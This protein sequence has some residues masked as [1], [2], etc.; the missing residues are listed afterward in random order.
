MVGITPRRISPVMGAR[1]ALAIS[2]TSSASRSSAFARPAM[3]V[4]TRVIS[5]CRFERSA[6]AVPST[7]SRSRMPAL[8]VD[9]VMWQRSAARPKCRVSASATRYWSCFI[10]GRR[11]IGGLSGK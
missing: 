6:T 3:V 11:F 7:D 2:I 10:V 9:W 8:S 4:P 1:S 5:T